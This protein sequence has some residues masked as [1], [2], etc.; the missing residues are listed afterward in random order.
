MFLRYV[1]RKFVLM[2][3]LSWCLA[4]S[5]WACPLIDGTVDYSDCN[6][7]GK[8]DAIGDSIVAAVGDTDLGIGYVGR[9]EDYYPDLKIVNQGIPG[10]TTDR[11]Y[12]YLKL[13]LAGKSSPLSKKGLKRSDQI[14]VGIGVNDFWKELSPGYT[15]RN[16]KRIVKLLQRR[17]NANVGIATL[18]TNNRWFQVGFVNA[19]NKK[20]LR[21]NSEDFPVVFRFDRLRKSQ[22]GSDGL[23]PNSKGYNRMTK[24]ARTAISGIWKD[25]ALVHRPDSDSDGI[26][27]YFETVRFGTD[28]NL[29]DTDSDGVSDGDEVFVYG[30][31]PLVAQ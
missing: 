15:I 25:I 6:G 14:I 21:L 31:D 24:I 16:I 30:T 28:P 29:A 19:V 18:S 27:D 7:H 26:F 17:L 22:I 8:L 5:A 11:L 12:R 23:H 4:T 13:S 2:V 3:L 10:L 9:L 1:Q 20:L